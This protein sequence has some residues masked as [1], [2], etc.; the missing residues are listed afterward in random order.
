MLTVTPKAPTQILDV[1]GVAVEFLTEPSARTAT[2]CVIKGTIPAGL[3]VPLH[4]H[5][6][7]ESFFVVS[8]EDEVLWEDEYGQLEWHRVAPG[9]FVHIRGGTKHAHRNRSP[10]AV[11][12][13]ITTS[14]Q[15]GRFFQ[16]AGRPLGLAGAPPTEGELQE[17]MELAERYGHW[18]ATPAENAAVGINLP[19]PPAR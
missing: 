14:T 2:Y 16:E 13:L 6:D 18:L 4:S 5:R 9:D 10:T 8:G 17:F 1:L 12:E 7:D 3:A 15:I 11:V 19:E